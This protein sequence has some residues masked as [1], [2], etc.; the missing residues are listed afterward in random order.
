[1]GFGLSRRDLSLREDPR[2]Q[3]QLE[4]S[5]ASCGCPQ[6]DCATETLTSPCPLCFQWEPAAR[7]CCRDENE[8]G[9]GEGLQ[10]SWCQ[11]RC[12]LMRP[13]GNLLL[14]VHWAPF[15]PGHHWSH[16]L[17]PFRTIC[18]CHCGL[19]WKLCWIACYCWSV[20]SKGRP[21]AA[22]KK[23]REKKMYLLNSNCGYKYTIRDVTSDL[24]S[25]LWGEVND[26][27]LP[28]DAWATRVAWT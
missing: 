21:T 19:H 11:F 7:W 16:H 17:H 3:Q 2:T 8:S 24:A 10:K 13:E 18:H 28:L 1:M 9:N 6:W 5:P 27:L 14:Q 15:Q 25:F 22:H 20:Q 12:R 26:L 4:T 23:K